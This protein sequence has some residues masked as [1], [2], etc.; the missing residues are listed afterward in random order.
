M[1]AGF[2]AFDSVPL[3]C[4]VP[5]YYFFLVAAP[6]IRN[7]FSDEEDVR[8]EH[9]INAQTSTRSQ[10]YNNCRWTMWGMLIM[11]IEMPPFVFPPATVGWKSILDICPKVAQ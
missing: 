11:K 5:M 7:Q 4:V 6:E 2:N 3:L 9:Y 10:H 1:N 8:A